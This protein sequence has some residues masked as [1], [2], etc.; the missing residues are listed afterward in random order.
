M[1]G[2][3]QHHITCGPGSPSCGAPM[4]L[5]HNYYFERLGGGESAQKV[6]KNMTVLVSPLNCF[7]SIK[8][9]TA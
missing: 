2:C 8:C 4:A 9:F 6:G 5:R 3:V 1:E 7:Y